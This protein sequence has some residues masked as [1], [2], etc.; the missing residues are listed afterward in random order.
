MVYTS[1]VISSPVEEKV[2]DILGNAPSTLTMPRFNTMLESAIF[3][4]SLMEEAYTDLMKEIGIS[5][6]AVYESTGAEVLYEAEDG[7]E[8]E[9]GKN[10]KDKAG[11]FFK[12]IWNGIKAMFEKAIA[13][14][15]EKMKVARANKMDK[16]KK[17]WEA[18]KDTIPD[19]KTFG[20]ARFLHIKDSSR[21]FSNTASALA[22]AAETAAQKLSK[23]EE[24]D[25]VAA[26]KNARVDVLGD[27]ESPKDFKAKLFKFYE[28]PEKGVPV[29]KAWVNDNISFL[30]DIVVNGVDTKAIKE[31]YK[32]LKA[33][34]NKLAS[35]AKKAKGDNFKANAKAAVKVLSF[36]SSA[37]SALI[38][39]MRSRYVEANTV[40][41]SVAVACKLGKKKK[42]AKGDDLAWFEDAWIEDKAATESAI[43]SNIESAF[44]W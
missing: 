4:G 26:F 20:K 25:V 14:F 30:T 6:L 11:D 28:V 7:T 9:A 19:D 36:I 17:A 3:V 1:K 41:T 22:T 37:D 12:K 18:K 44:E 27:V 33:R 24:T 31:M 16:V 15:Q 39:I 42:D 5:E 40:A 43:I 2:E 13:W 10:L 38:D 29:T 34:V 32:L 35:D 8:T 23:G 21:K